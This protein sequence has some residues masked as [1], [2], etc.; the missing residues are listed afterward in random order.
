[1]EYEYT[2]LNGRL[3]VNFEGKTTK[4][5]VQSLAAIQ[6]VCEQP[7]CS[8]CGNADFVFVHRLVD[9]DPYHEL[10]CKKCHWKLG[11]SIPKKG[12][13]NLYPRWKNQATGQKIGPKGDGWHFYE[14]E[15]NDV[16]DETEEVEDKP[17]MKVKR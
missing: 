3:K 9:G 8:N 10:K 16:D 12:D 4:E 5:L 11:F 14:K 2:T 7:P 15:R 1:M 17:K 6:A 13:G